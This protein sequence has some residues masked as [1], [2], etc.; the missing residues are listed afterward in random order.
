[1]PLL[2][3]IILEVL[4]R[5]SR[6]EKETDIPIRKEEVKLSLFTDNIILFLENPKD[7]TCEEV[8]SLSCIQL[9]DPMDRSLPGSSVHGI[10]HTRI[11][12]WV[13]ISFCRQGVDF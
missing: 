3:N 1:M 4:G 13:A 11:L 9:C 2:V 12:E 5:A 6:Q 7:H 8:K 10:F